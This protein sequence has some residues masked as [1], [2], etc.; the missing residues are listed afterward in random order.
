MI[1]LIVDVST[2]NTFFIF[3]GGGRQ[4]ISTEAA[5]PPCGLCWFRI[6]VYKIISS[7]CR[8][9]MRL[10]RFLHNVRDTYMNVS[11]IAID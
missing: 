10:L 9:E 4:L 6:H 11:Y 3:W 1:S 5:I 2:F 7:S 8:F